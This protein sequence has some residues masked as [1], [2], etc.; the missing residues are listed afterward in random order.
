M[1][2]DKTRIIITLCLFLGIFILPWW[3]LAVLF[4]LGFIKINYYYEGLILALIYDI[5]YFIERDLFLGLPVFFVSL[6]IFFIFSES[7][8]KQLRV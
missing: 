6:V 3:L 4:I 8:R 5:F 7:V 2:A 1:G